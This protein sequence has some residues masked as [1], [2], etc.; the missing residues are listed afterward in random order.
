[1][2]CDKEVARGDLTALTQA[3]R[4]TVREFSYLLFHHSYG[5]HIFQRP[6]SPTLIDGIEG[7]H[8]TFRPWT[9][10]TVEQIGLYL[11]GGY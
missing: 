7:A 9:I 10:L 1:M 4:S 3:E 5:E 2:N 11:A 6:G 8:Q